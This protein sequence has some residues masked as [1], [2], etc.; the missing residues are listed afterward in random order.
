LDLSRLA[1]P[2]SRVELLSLG[3]NKRRIH[4]LALKPGL[5]QAELD[6]GESVMP[7]LY[8]SMASRTKVGPGRTTLEKAGVKTQDLA[9][10]R[11]DTWSCLDTQAK[12]AASNKPFEEAE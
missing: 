10:L 3:G 7:R 1:W 6:S 8:I 5:A 12:L 11:Q 4:C 9:H 2:P